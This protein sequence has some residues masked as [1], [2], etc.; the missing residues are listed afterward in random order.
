MNRI[1][2]ASCFAALAL[3]WLRLGAAELQ[4]GTAAVNITPPPGAPMAGY[5]YNR[6]AEGV[7]DALH[8]KALV[9][10]QGGAKA[11]LV[12]CDVSSLPR[13]IVEQ[14][15][16][17]I[18]R[19]SGVPAENVMISAT[20]THTGPVV[21]GPHSRYRLTGEM[22]RIA[23]EYRAALPAKI[24]ESVRLAAGATQPARLW[25]G[26]GHEP[27]LTF[28]RR[29]HM[30]DG[31][32]G[33][34]PGKLN[35]N[36]VRPAG[37][38]DPAVGVVYLDTPEGTALATYVNYAL[39]LDTVGGL[40]YSADYPYTLG[41][42]LRAVKGEQM[43]TM[44]TIGCAGNLNHIDVSSA[45]RQ[46]GHREAARI[47]AILAAEVLKTYRK[48]EPVRAAAPVTLSEMVQLPLASF[49]AAQLD[50]A[51]NT[52][53]TFSGPN[54]APFMDLV[55]AFKILDVAERQGAPLEAEVQVIAFGR[56]VA[57][58]GLPG[59][60]FT[61]LGLSIKLNSPFRYTTVVELANGS[62]GY[63][64]NRKAYQEGAY[65][66][67]SARCG[68]GAGEMLVEAAGR[69]L[70]QAAEKSRPQRR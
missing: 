61:E 26:L 31:T 50:W 15:R 38:I 36:I 32:V 14:A 30:K 60:I 47:G 28:N 8:A 23:E 56:D 33:W 68:P 51:R 16:Q 63:V 69:L 64:P 35:P 18:A 25:A 22:L 42:I 66:V 24:A 29:F 44:F 4:I 58:V 67:V 49:D 37:P 19:Q 10:S 7:H 53:A 57:W 1:I 46:K 59:E 39:H 5:Y 48:L 2:T 27:S 17:L 11:A 21:L 52:A 65:E 13:P 41:K 55:R 6:G 12:V 40:E 45:E 34:N 3:M 70:A 20:H 43:L 54:A 62:I 9:F